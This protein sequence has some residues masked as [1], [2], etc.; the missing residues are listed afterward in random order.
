MNDQN[1]PPSGPPTAPTGAA[2]HQN[3][4]T[5][6]VSDRVYSWHDLQQAL[7]KAETVEQVEAI[8]RAE[9]AGPARLRWLTRIQGRRAVLRSIE[10]SEQLAKLAK[11]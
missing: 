10:E 8:L 4:P 11:E 2:S 5:K 7:R 3:E 1:H 9:A 6:P